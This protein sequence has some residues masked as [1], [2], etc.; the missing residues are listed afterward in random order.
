MK[1][2]IK[3]SSG[4]T[5]SVSII[6]EMIPQGS[7]IHS[8][9]LFDAYLELTLAEDQR[10]V[11]GH[12]PRAAIY[13]FWQCMKVDPERLYL[14]TKE[15]ST[16]VSNERI[17]Q[18]LQKS[19]YTYADPY[20]RSALF[21]LLNRCTQDGKISAGHIDVNGFNPLSLSTMRGT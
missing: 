14:M 1:S 17:L 13:D 18:T 20:L 16:H 21:F 7:V 9:G 8:Y 4:Q 2:P 6:K 5:K 19:W 15:Q 3:S 10:F 11:I 12:T